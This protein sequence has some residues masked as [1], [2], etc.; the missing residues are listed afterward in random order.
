MLSEINTYNANKS[1]STNPETTVTGRA[2]DSVEF[3]QAG[4]LLKD[5]KQLQTSDPAEFKQVL[6]DAATQL[7]T[8]A[9]QQTDPGAA[10]FLNNLSDR[11]QKAADTGD[12][13]ALKPNTPAGGGYKAHGHHGGHHR[14]PDNDASSTST[15]DAT[16]VMDLVTQSLAATPAASQ[17]GAQVQSLLS[18]L[19]NTTT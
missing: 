5:L 2:A 7:K 13:S 10:S 19:I 15:T 14:Q 16:N 6:S 18:T 12:L 9:G 4:Q 8:A 1:A 11:F 3:S 17:T